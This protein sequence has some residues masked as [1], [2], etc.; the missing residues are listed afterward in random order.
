MKET[1]TPS[2]W[3]QHLV[4]WRLM[5]HR[6]VVEYCAFPHA[7]MVLRVRDFSEGWRQQGTCGS[8]TLREGWKD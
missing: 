2:C 3:A 7:H 6:P 5:A 1:S 4:R 8:Q